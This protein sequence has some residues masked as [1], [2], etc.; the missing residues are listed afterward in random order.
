[1]ISDKEFIDSIE[2]G[3]SGKSQIEI[4]FDKWR[5]DT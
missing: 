4:R 2:K 5:M 3:T 1:M